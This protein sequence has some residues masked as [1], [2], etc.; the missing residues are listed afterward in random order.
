MGLEMSKSD[1]IA[2]LG[3]TTYDRDIIKVGNFDVPNN[4]VTRTIYI[5]GRGEKWAYLWGAFYKVERSG[6]YGY[7]TV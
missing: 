4:E 2:F 5:D 7:I 1:G 3:L 6:H